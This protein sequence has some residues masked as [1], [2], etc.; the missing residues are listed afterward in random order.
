MRHCVPLGRRV[1]TRCNILDMSASR[2]AGAEVRSRKEWVGESCEC[3]P[4][5]PQPELV[6]DVESESWQYKASKAASM[7]PCVRVIG[8]AISAAAAISVSVSSLL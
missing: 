2:L 8:G 4:G 5:V 7:P 1:S 3:G 6:L